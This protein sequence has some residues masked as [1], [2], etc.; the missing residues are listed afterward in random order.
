MTSL[1]MHRFSVPRLLLWVGLGLLCSLPEL[2]LAVVVPGYRGAPV[3]T[4][5]LMPLGIA[6]IGEWARSDDARLDLF[7]LQVLRADAVLARITA[8]ALGAVFV[9]AATNA[10]V[11]AVLFQMPEV[12][13]ALGWTLCG[14]LVALAGFV[15]VRPERLGGLRQV[16]ICIVGVAVASGAFD[17]DTR[18]GLLGPQAR[19]LLPALVA[20][21][22]TLA[23]GAVALRLRHIDAAGLVRLACWIAAG[24]TTFTASVL[25]MPQQTAIE[26]LLLLPALP[27]MGLA[28][29][30][31]LF[32]PVR[33]A[34][35]V[36]V[37]L[38]LG[39]LL[40][41]LAVLGAGAVLHRDLGALPG[42]LSFVLAAVADLWLLVALRRFGAGAAA[43]GMGALILLRLALPLAVE[44]SAFDGVA[45]FLHR[46]IDAAAL[47]GLIGNA[48][49]IALA[50]ALGFCPVPRLGEGR[51]QRAV[52]FCLRLV[53]TFLGSA[54]VVAT[55]HI[56]A[57]TR[58]GTLP[59]AAGLGYTAAVGVALQQFALSPQRWEAMRLGRAL[60]ARHLLVFALPAV[61]AATAALLGSAV[62]TRVD[63][64]D[65]VSGLTHIALLPAIALAIL[66]AGARLD[67]T[68]RCA[69]VMS[70]P[71][72]VGAS[73]IL[74]GLSHEIRDAASP[75]I[76]LTIALAAIFAWRAALGRIPRDVLLSIVL[77]VG[78]AL[79]WFVATGAGLKAFGS[80]SSFLAMAMLLLFVAA[81]QRRLGRGGL[82]VWLMR[83]P[84]LWLALVFGLVFALRLLSPFDG[85]ITPF[86]P[87][88][89]LGAVLI[90]LA[91]RLHMGIG[92]ILLMLVAWFGEVRELA[93]A[94]LLAMQSVLSPGTAS[95]SLD[96]MA[97]ALA[98]AAALALSLALAQ[99]RHRRRLAGA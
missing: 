45:G 21:S 84:L 41:A 42:L 17:P 99:W 10:A 11:A 9:V 29:A 63:L 49:Q 74:S 71:L 12:F 20:V 92:P 60:A 98:G 51:G 94:M 78:L 80:S 56:L 81:L 54:A 38:A 96:D 26:R 76:E 59:Q 58:P 77:P 7:P 28:L 33:A 48:A 19:A 23:W 31:A 91:L 55:I 89:L 25:W 82:R 6:L 30:V 50:I 2:C 32:E 97:V 64:L 34:R 95:V 40:A 15:A 14:W 93:Q 65:L 47:N 39:P 68:L 53:A 13:A 3:A 18:L 57:E 86:H 90:V 16:A 8:R 52:G 44:R 61:L 27:A 88:I 37:P 79:L 69:L 46:D 62:F 75:A 4:M 72:S 5:A 66:A 36:T 73:T 22:V 24:A 1:G 83:L 70:L 85:F 67:F 35:R 43:A 87:D